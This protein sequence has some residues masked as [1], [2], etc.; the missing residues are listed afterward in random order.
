MA[1]R[2]G[3]AVWGATALHQRRVDWGAAATRGLK[4]VGTGRG[5]GRKRGICIAREQTTKTFA[6][7]STWT[8]K[9]PLPTHQQEQEVPEMKLPE[10]SSDAAHW[11]STVMTFITQPDT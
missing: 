3:Q 10:R 8:Y 9:L 7:T 4:E 6:G 11:I 5:G 1:A 2:Q